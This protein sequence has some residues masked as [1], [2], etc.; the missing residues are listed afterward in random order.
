MAV[1]YCSVYGCKNPESHTTDGHFCNIC[2]SFGHG[3]KECKNNF[4]RK[5][6]EKSKVT[7]LPEVDW[8]KVEGCT[9]KNNHKTNYHRCTYCLE[10]SEHSIYSCDK[11][12][13]DLYNT[14]VSDDLLRNNGNQQ[15]E[16]RVNSRQ[17]SKTVTI[18]KC[19]YCRTVGEID[20]DRE[21]YTDS[22]CNVCYEHKKKLLFLS[23]N[24]ALTCKEC[25]IL[26]NK[27][28]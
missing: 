10:L 1:L 17:S 19:N 13:N 7:S 2:K 27:N 9:S 4:R 23:C 5:L 28:M 22:K 3:D 11:Y 8:C 26:E 20:M 24:H 14:D 25:I 16:L 6:L 15:S 21:I 12:I 18:A